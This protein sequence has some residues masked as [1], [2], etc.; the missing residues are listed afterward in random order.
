MN[1]ETLAQKFELFKEY[2][3]S[4]KE[5]DLLFD[6]EENIRAKLNQDVLKKFKDDVSLFYRMLK[7]S[8]SGKYHEIPR[9]TVSVIVCT[10]LYLRSPID[11]I[12]DFIPGA[13]FTDDAQILSLCQHFVS[14]D[15]D[16]YK[17][18][19]HLNKEINQQK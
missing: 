17:I 15:I 9:E 10:L 6:E 19:I 12:P 1:Q 16:R 11:V 18:F 13:G 3:Y 2:D 5:I 7:D 4:E 14:K 8:F